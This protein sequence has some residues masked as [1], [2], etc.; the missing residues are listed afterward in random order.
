MPYSG[1]PPRMRQ[2][3]WRRAVFAHNY[4]SEGFALLA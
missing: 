3:G 1:F 2:V 4:V